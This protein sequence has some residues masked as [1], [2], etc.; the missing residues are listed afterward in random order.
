MNQEFKNYLVVSWDKVL[1]NREDILKLFEEL[2]LQDLDDIQIISRNYSD[3]N[4]LIMLIEANDAK[5]ETL[6][7]IIDA[8]SGIPTWQQ[9]SRIEDCRMKVSRINGKNF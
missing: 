7:I 9:F 1:S 4:R 3:D 2:D 5:D 6:K 8:T